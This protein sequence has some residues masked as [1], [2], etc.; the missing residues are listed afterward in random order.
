MDIGVN[1]AAQLLFWLLG[2]IVVAGWLRRTSVKRFREFFGLKHN[3]SLDIYLS[4]MKLAKGKPGEKLSD[5]GISLEELWAAQSILRLFSTAPARV[6]GVVRALVDEILLPLPA[7]V[8]AK[9]SPPDY[10]TSKSTNIIAIGSAKHNTVRQHYLENTQ[11]PF[12]ILSPK[13]K[14][15][16]GSL[17]KVLKGDHKDKMFQC[18]NEKKESLA[19]IERIY[20]PKIRTVIFMCA[21]LHSDSSWGAAEYLVRNWKSLSKEHGAGPFALFLRF[22]RTSGA[23]NQAYM[24]P[25]EKRTFTR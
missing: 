23:P 10:S 7:E 6:P 17:V 1:L 5:Q 16:G 20:D 11:H 18:E 21:G 8:R 19:I 24:A 2:G 12:L 9:I 13:D 14:E 25:L 4:R 22:P 15:L 3:G